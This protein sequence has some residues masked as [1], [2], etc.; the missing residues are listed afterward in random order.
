M[1]NNER[2]SEECSRCNGFGKVSVVCTSCGGNPSE[3]GGCSTCDNAGWVYK[4][5]PECRGSG[6]IEVV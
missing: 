2:S 1:S 3:H 6:R 5:C 4:T